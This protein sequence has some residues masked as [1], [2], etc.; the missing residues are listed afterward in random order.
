MGAMQV[1]DFLAA[2]GLD[3][4]ARA[5][6]ILSARPGEVS[7][8]GEAF[9]AAA[10]AL[11]ASG[12]L[13]SLAGQLADASAVFDGASPT[14]LMAEVSAVRDTLA[15]GPQ[16]LAGLGAQ[17]STL[18]GRTAIAQQQVSAALM[19]MQEKAGQVVLNYASLADEM[20]IG[21]QAWWE[22]NLADGVGI[23]QSCDSAIAAIV[24]EY[25]A[26]LGAVLLVL[27]SAGYLLPPDVDVGL[28]T[29]STSATTEVLFEY[30]DFGVPDP[31]GQIPVAT[32]WW[33]SLSAAEQA[34]MLQANPSLVAMMRGLPA[35]AYHAVN[36]RALIDDSVDTDEQL[37]EVCEK[38][39]NTLWIQSVAPR[40]GIESAAELATMPSWKMSLLMPMAP[41]V[42]GSLPALREK[43]A[44]IN[45][46]QQSITVGGDGKDRYL[47]E[48]DSAAYDGDGLAT[49]AIGEVDTAE[50]VAVVVQGANHDLGTITAQ[51]ADA[52]AVL[53]EMDAMSDDENAVIVYG[54]YDNPTILQSPFTERAEYAGQVLA[55]DLAGYAAAHHEAS[56]GA[57]PHTT[58]IGHSYGTVVA[59]EALKD[60][61]SAYA[62]DV[63]LY[64]SPGVDA[65]DIGD[66]GMTSGHVFVSMTPSDVLI[67]ASGVSAVLTGHPLSMN[68]YDSSFGATF[69]GWDGVDDHGDYFG[70]ENGEPNQTLKGAAAVAVQQSPGD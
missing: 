41:M 52:E 43:A 62:D 5:E 39:W 46:V 13:S 56:G 28:A 42:L 49:I 27:Q 69:I 61:A 47:L 32:A 60:G 48:Y 20:V 30:A 57:D 16:V 2:A 29:P 35:D 25:D 70:Y 7:A 12:S 53:G 63:V 66:L 4:H 64:G 68:V 38:L 33:A 58:I 31:H 6:A 55:D 10:D 8:L 15:A 65:D 24:D 22:M 3:P 45:G 67:G 19:E 17:L 40:L 9:T 54:G 1:A 51:T 14:D 11:L 18:A 44:T 34:V 21:A 37:Q 59:A 26:D 23:V 36:A 50:N